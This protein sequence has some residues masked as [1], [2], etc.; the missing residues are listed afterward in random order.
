LKFA[1]AGRIFWQKQL[2][3]I[4]SRLSKIDIELCN[5]EKKKFR[6]SFQTALMRNTA[7]CS[8]EGV[9]TLGEVRVHTEQS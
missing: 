2:P 1:E 3:K 8:D 7:R 4:S 9:K 5:S 6:D